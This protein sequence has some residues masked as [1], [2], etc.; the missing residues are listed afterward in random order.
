ME[1]G[2]TLR[3]RWQDDIGL[4]TIR[5]IIS[6]KVPQWPTGL[7]DWQL[8]LV[9]KILDGECLLCSA[10]TSDGKSALFGA[11]AVILVEISKNPSLYPPLPRKEKPV[12]IV[13]TP[14]KGLSANIVCDYALLVVL[15]LTVSCYRSTSSKSSGSKHYRTA[16]RFL[17][18]R[19]RQ[20]GS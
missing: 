16:R 3:L 10:A 8:P 7:H 1:L 5:S 11:P 20:G 4:E 9:A 12:S 14:T 2:N 19:G 13:I 17:P 6:K 15:K 18:M